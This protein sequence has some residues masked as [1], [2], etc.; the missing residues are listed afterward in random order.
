M[1]PSPFTSQEETKF[2]RT[3]VIRAAISSDGWWEADNDLLF[4]KFTR[5]TTKQ[6]P[7]QSADRQSLDVDDV[8]DKSLQLWAKSSGVAHAPPES[9]MWWCCDIEARHNRKQHEKQN[10]D[11]L[12]KFPFRVV[13]EV[14][15]ICGES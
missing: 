10:G 7:E 4:P 13:H 6:S 11:N 15:E 12:S 8:D 1:T 14:S 5:K 2:L 3:A 9:C